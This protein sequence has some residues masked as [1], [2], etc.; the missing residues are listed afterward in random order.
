M[1]D[2]GLRVP[3]IARWPAAIKP[4]TASEAIGHSND[5]LPTFCDAAGIEL[6]DDN[7]LDGLSLLPHLKGA[8]PPTARQRGTLLW[9]LDLYKKIQ[10]PY[11]KPGP[12]ATEVAIQ[13]KWK[14]LARVGNPVELFDIEEDP[15][16]LRN[17]M[18]ENPAMV[19]SLRIEI[20]QFL[21]AP[22]E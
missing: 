6:P 16:E 2:G 11:P 12:Y 21:K 19:S 3:M 8:A 22:R 9:Q 20:E 15:N 5:L 14:L 1:H 17:V 18:S 4:G 10:R 13:G 7:S